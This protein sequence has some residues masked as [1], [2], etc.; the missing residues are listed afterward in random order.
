MHETGPVLARVVHVATDNLRAFVKNM[1][2][3]GKC[4]SAPARLPER[5]CQATCAAQPRPIPRF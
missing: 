4:R 2:A 3:R 5:I 1:A